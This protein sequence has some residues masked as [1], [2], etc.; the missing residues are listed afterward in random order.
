MPD[1]PLTNAQKSGCKIGVDTTRLIT[2]LDLESVYEALMESKHENSIESLVRGWVKINLPLVTSLNPVSIHLDQLLYKTPKKKPV[3]ISS[4]LNIFTIL[5]KIL[6]E[7]QVP[8]KPILTIP[9]A[10]ISNE[11]TSDI[12]RNLED[13]TNQLNEFESPSF[14]LADW[15]PLKWIA[16]CEEI[17]IPL[18]FKLLD[19]EFANDIYVYYREFRYGRAIRFN[20]EYA[21]VI[22]AEYYPDGVRIQ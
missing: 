17:N 19:G 22:Y 9:L 14:Y 21:R 15:G 13:L 20:S 11:I 12:P 2:Q 18:P 4:S 10:E 6:R 16:L 7:H 1:S 3:I 8:V 5:V